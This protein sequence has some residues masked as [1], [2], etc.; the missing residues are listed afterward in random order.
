MGVRIRVCVCVC[1]RM[2]GALRE[3]VEGFLI[4]ALV[5]LSLQSVRQRRVS[6]ASLTVSALLFYPSI[7]LLMFHCV[8]KRDRAM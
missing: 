5:N 7:Q 1:V 2:R 4:S 8:H 3:R 6:R